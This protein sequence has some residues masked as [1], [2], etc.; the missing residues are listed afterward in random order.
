M[1]YTDLEFLLYC[2]KLKRLNNHS[3]AA[4]LS[5]YNS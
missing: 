2:D 5:Q 1:K 4:S 3:N